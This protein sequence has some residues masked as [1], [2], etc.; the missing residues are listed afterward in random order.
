MIKI[1]KRAAVKAAKISWLQRHLNYLS[2]SEHAD[3]KNKVSILPPSIRN[4]DKPSRDEFV[5]AVISADKKYRE[6][7]EG[8]RGKRT[9]RL[10]D[11]TI[12]RTPDRTDLNV[13]ERGEVEESILA[14]RPSEPAYL[15]WHHNYLRESW[16]LH[17]ITPA[18]SRGW[19][20]GVILSSEYGG[21]RK[22]IFAEL[23]MR[24]HELVERLNQK[25][26]PDKKI[27]SARRRREEKSKNHLKK[28]RMRITSLAEL[29]A[30]NTIEKV[31]SSQQLKTVMN[32]TRVRIK[33]ISSAFISVIW[34]GR[35]QSRRYALDKLFIDIREAQ[36]RVYNRDGT[37]V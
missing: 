35:K 30:K 14:M 23:E 28:S 29:I 34:P 15:Q 10:W 3:H 4:L 31:E 13:I 16:D 25:R 21:G 26:S 7:R 36:G 33:R 24:D 20:P 22:H 18:K 1:V 6:Y 27:T 32:Q 37:P 11:E 8:K 2:N 9:E 19:P 5:N 12:Y 17:V